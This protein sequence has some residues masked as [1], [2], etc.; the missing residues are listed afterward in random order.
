VGYLRENAIAQERVEDQRT[1]LFTRGSVIKQ[2]NNNEKLLD[3][4][5]LGFFSSFSFVRVFFFWISTVLTQYPLSN[6][7]YR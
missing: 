5:K 4:L 3:E 7:H 1:Y 6:K 2:R